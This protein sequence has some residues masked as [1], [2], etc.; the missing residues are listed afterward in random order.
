V[1]VVEDNEIVR[2]LVCETLE[3]HGYDVIEAQSPS[4][5]LEY[6][7]GKDSVHLLLTDVIMPKMNGKELYQKL[8]TIHP[9]SKVLYMS[10]YTNDVIVHYGILDEG[11]SF[12]QKPFTI[13]GL[14]R[15]IRE[16]LD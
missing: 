13:R 11:I 1:L 5:C 3:A 8:I 15:K 7:S 14:T 2:K 9:N 4:E 6:A 10:G 12:L 16:V